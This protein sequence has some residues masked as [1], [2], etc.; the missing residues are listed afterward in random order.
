MS[1]NLRNESIEN[2]T[3]AIWVNK[4]QNNVKIKKSLQQIGH[5]IQVIDG[6]LRIVNISYKP[7]IIKYG[8]GTE[9]YPHDI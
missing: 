6:I 7:P 4:N 8:N 2:D 3:A 5:D 9:L 1:F